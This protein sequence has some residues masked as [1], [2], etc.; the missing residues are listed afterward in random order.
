MDNILS[1]FI[2]GIV[3]RHQSLSLKQ[4]IGELRV[5]KTGLNGSVWI[6][7]RYSGFRLQT[8]GEVASLLDKE[9]ERLQGNSSGEHKGYKYWHIDDSQIVEELIDIL[10]KA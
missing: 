9:I 2:K 1:E 7:T 5:T 10:G 6:K 4:N 8:T 3:S